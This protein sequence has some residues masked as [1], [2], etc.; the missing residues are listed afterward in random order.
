MLDLKFG[1]EIASQGEKKDLCYT[2]SDEKKPPYLADLGENPAPVGGRRPGRVDPRSSRTA[3]NH[4]C[5]IRL[6]WTACLGWI[7]PAWAPG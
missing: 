7:Y 5:A 1:L 3:V 4:C 6:C 2:C